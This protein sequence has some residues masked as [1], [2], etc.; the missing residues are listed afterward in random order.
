M[1]APSAVPSVIRLLPAGIRTARLRRILDA[2]VHL[3]GFSEPR[4]DRLPAA[5]T[6][7]LGAPGEAVTVTDRREGEA[8][9]YR[10]EAEAAD[11]AERIAAVAG[12][13][14]GQRAKV[15]LDPSACFIRS[16][17]LPSAALPRMRDLLAEELEAATPFRT[18][19]VYSDW[20]VEGEHVASRTLRVRHVVVKK[21][22][23]DPLLDALAAA[24]LPAG[25]VAVGRAEDQ[26][27]PVDLLSHGHRALPALFGGERRGDLALWIGAALLLAGAVWGWRAHQDATL[28][29]LDDA[30]AAARHSAATVPPP[31]QAGL[32]AILASRAPPLAGTWDALAAALP[33]GASATALHLDGTG[34]RLVLSVR[35]EA[36]TLAALGRLPGFGLPVL[37]GAENEAG[38][39]RRLTLNLPRAV[40]DRRP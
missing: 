34:M 8:R 3:A 16:L 32:A 22:R 37:Q 19:A 33:D 15:I 13:R 5:L 30:F 11:L 39:N 7:R 9:T 38:G 2:A 21:A 18:A 23:L 1:S 40:E 17:D 35:D 10:F 36:G 20:F 24:G 14:G 4:T 6:V 29:A 28:A 26:T 31:V 27:L 25:P 12:G